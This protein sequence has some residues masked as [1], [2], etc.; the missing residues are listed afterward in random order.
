MKRNQLL[1]KVYTLFICS[2]LFFSGGMA[3]AIVTHCGDNV[4]NVSTPSE[5]MTVAERQAEDADVA[6]IYGATILYT[7]DNPSATSRYNC[8]NYA[9]HRV[10]GGSRCWINFTGAAGNNIW[11]TSGC[12]VECSISQA[13]KVCYQYDHSAVRV[14]NSTFRS[15]W[16]SSSL[17]QHAPGN[18][19]SIYGNASKYYRLRDATLTANFSSTAV[20]PCGTIQFTDTSTVQDCTITSWSW[21]FGDGTTSAQR[22]PSHAYTTKGNKS[23]TLT[24][25]GS[26]GATTKSITKTVNVVDCNYN[27]TVHTPSGG[28][29]LNKN[30]WFEITWTP[31]NV[32]GNLRLELL[33][34]G[35]YAG[36]IAGTVSNDGDR[37]WYLD[38]LKGGVAINPGSNY[39][40]RIVSKKFPKTD[41]KSGYFTIA[42]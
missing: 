36:T 27:I 19:P 12:F 15:K 31:A 10:D 11:V 28:Q 25:T 18:V 14:N 13:T 17:C 22:H 20:N 39:Q 24:I 29:T 5:S 35:S 37:D 9:W 38:E 32:T 4:P 16:G 33:Q 3:Y 1:K 30:T 2:F 21:N 34:N 6:S 7:Y 42:N 26:W 8:H 41:G 23:V 40:V